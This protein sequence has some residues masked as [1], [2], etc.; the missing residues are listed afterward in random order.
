MG[1]VATPL[2]VLAG[3]GTV[4]AATTAATSGNGDIYLTA[5]GPLRLGQVTTAAGAAQTVNVSTTGL[6]NALTLA[7]SSATSDNWTLNSSGAIAF[8]GPTT[9]TAATAAPTAV[10]AITSSTT[11][12]DIDT[13]AANGPIALDGA[14]WGPP[15]IPWNS[16]PAAAL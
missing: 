9:L 15:P 5:A 7:A 3:T 11:T 14:T 12:T 8:S 6:N 1:T 4:T 2:G 10:G 13:S 16:I